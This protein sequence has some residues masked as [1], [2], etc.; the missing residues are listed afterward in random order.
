MSLTSLSS[1]D[2]KRIIK[3]LEVKEKLQAQLAKVDQELTRISGEPAGKKGKT[4]T[5]KPV[6]KQPR[7][8]VKR[9][10]VELLKA[11]GREGVTVKEVAA[12]LGVSAGRV[13]T[14]FY[15]TGK[16]VSQIKKIGE[17]RYRWEN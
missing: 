4:G 9:A 15:S 1:A 10:I 14:W 11:G 3:L 2:F 13:Y 12:R 7:G 17:A 5:P 6:R 8:Q 16:N